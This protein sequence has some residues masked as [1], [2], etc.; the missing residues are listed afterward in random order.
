[1]FESVL[2]D[3]DD[4][5]P[6]IAKLVDR[7]S[8][9]CLSDSKGLLAQR[10]S[11][12]RIRVYVT[13]TVPQDWI[14]DS[15]ISFDQTEQVRTQLLQMFED[16]EDNLLNLIRFGESNFIPQPIYML[17]VDHHWQ[18]QPGVTLLGDAAHLMSPFAGQGA[19]LAMLDAAELALAIIGSED[20][21]QA[22]HDY[23]QKM[24]TR[25]KK[26]AEKAFN[27]LKMFFSP[28]NAA[29]ITADYVENVMECVSQSDKKKTIDEP[30]EN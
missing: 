24:F 8:L 10:N 29:K 20:L 13:L 30:I 27:N 1:M 14:T 19:N 3:V 18:T 16:W 7:G 17:P 22:I 4:Q 26:A 21:D 25:A 28:G 9:F 15:G 23:E 6:E 5:H 12:N 2:T 11:K